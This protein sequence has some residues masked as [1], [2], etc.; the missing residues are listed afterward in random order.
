L[1]YFLQFQVISGL[2]KHPL[3][4]SHILLRVGTAKGSDSL[5]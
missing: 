4:F 2:K 5:Q 3:E 1:C